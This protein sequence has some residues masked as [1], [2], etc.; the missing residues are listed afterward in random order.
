MRFI[1]NAQAAAPNR[2]V[3]EE[4]FITKDEVA[5]R[6]KKTTRTIEIWQRKGLIPYVKAGKSVLYSWPD[7][8][9]HLQSKFGVCRSGDKRD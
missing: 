5:R 2:Q 6:L 8:A 1:Q 9:E 3:V 7:V 4:G